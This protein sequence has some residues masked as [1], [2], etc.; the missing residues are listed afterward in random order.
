MSDIRRLQH[1]MLLLRSDRCRHSRRWLAGNARSGVYEQPPDASLN[2]RFSF[3]T[4][5]LRHLRWPHLQPQRDQACSARWCQYIYRRQVRGPCETPMPSTLATP[6][7]GWVVWKSEI[8]VSRYI[9][10]VTD[11]P[12]QF[13]KMKIGFLRQGIT[14]TLTHELS[15]QSPTSPPPPP[16]PSN[17]TTANFFSSF[18]SLIT[19]THSEND[20]RKYDCTRSEMIPVLD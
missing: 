1:T 17:L 13:F 8:E 19:N 5:A 7:R 3:S 18:L 16:E 10:R 14:R 6:H 11:F 15:L 20:V 12:L 4:P 2:F 9:T